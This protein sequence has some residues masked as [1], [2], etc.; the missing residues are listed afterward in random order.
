MEVKNIDEADDWFAVLQT[1]KKTQTAVMTLEP[2]KSSGE[3]PEAHKNSEQVLIVLEG[4]IFAEIAQESGTLKK[5]DVVVIPAGVAHKFTNKSKAR[6]VTFNT[7]SP[8][9]Y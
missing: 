6:V 1:H 3:K 4:E 2:G 5:N 8:P 9:E 7:Y